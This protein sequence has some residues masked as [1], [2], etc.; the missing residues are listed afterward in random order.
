MAITHGMNVDAVRG[1]A[2]RLDRISHQ[3][4]DVRT[5]TDHL[6]QEAVR[7]WAGTDAQAFQD[8]W[9][10]RYRP[11]LVN[12]ARAVEDLSRSARQNAD[13]QDE[14]SNGDGAGGGQPTSSERTRLENALKIAEAAAG[15]LSLDSGAVD[16]LNKLA[17]L[18]ADK[19]WWTGATK[20]DLAFWKSIPADDLAFFRKLGQIGGSLSLAAAVGEVFLDPTKPDSWISA[21]SSGF[22]LVETLTKGGVSTTFGNVASGLNVG[23][24]AVKSVRAFQDGDPAASIYYGLHGVA[25]TVG[26][27]LPPVRLGLAAWDTGTGIGT[28]IGTAYVN[29]SLGQ[30]DQQAALDWGARYVDGD[31]TT[32]PAAAAALTKRYEGVNGFGHFLSDTASSKAYQLG[33]WLAG[34]K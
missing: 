26:V 14:A 23:L 13:Q 8:R 34:G 33:S 2:D 9:Q 6:T 10:T 30:A 4:D 7:A 24:D 21:G 1:L 5:A 16:A 22:G 25:A 29:S 3:I 18:P 15:A 31:P 32:D 27:A 12:A 17:K 11:G 20:D 19:Q 28:A